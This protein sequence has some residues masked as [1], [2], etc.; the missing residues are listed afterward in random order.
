MTP[1][2]LLIIIADRNDGTPGT[3]MSRYEGNYSISVTGD[4][5]LWLSNNET[6]E[7][8]RTWPA[9]MWQEVNIRDNRVAQ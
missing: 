5:E 9:G 7:T 6:Q 4:G 2:H 3:V 1:P 8:E